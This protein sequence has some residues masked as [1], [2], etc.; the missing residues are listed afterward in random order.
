V[1]CGEMALAAPGVV[2]V[3]LPWEVAG[4]AAALHLRFHFP[5]AARPADV[6]PGARDQRLLGFAFRQL[7]LA[8][9]LPA[10][11]EKAGAA[12]PAATSPAAARPAA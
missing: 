10:A 7:S 5:D 2:R 12:R 1:A 9:P 11:P 3:T 6:V 4:R 8:G